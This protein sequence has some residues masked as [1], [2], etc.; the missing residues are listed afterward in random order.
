MPLVAGALPPCVFP[1]VFVAG[2]RFGKMLIFPGSCF[3][4]STAL[5][6]TFPVPVFFED[7]SQGSRVTPGLLSPRQ[8]QTK[9]R[10]E[11]TTPGW[12]GK[13]R[14]SKGN[15]RHRSR[16]E[17]LP[18]AGWEGNSSKYKWVSSYSCSGNSLLL[19]SVEGQVAPLRRSDSTGQPCEWVNSR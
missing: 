15:S 18:A 4:I 3:S 9:P 1:S 8:L 10:W 12:E 6:R 2:T 7:R 5:V 14:V 11:V 13:E 19:A 16:W 17:R